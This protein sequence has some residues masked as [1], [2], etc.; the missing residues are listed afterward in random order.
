MQ[1]LGPGA[2]GDETAAP[3]SLQR[4][5]ELA[6]EPLGLQPAKHH[7]ALLNALNGVARGD[8]DRLMV[9]MPPGSAKSTYASLLFP[10]W[11]LSRFPR[12]SIIATSHTQDLA[13]HFGR[14]LR[15]VA[16]D[17]ARLLGYGFE[18]DNNAAYRFR[19]SLGGEYFATGL[20]GGITGRRADLVLI[21][22][23]IKNHSAADSASHR[24]GVWN[25]YRSE[26]S[27]RLK[28]RGRVVLIMTR[29]HVDDLG[30]RLAAAG[31]AWETLRLPAL[32]EANDPLGREPGA[33][34]WPEWE[35]LVQLERRRTM[36]GSR[37]WSALYQQ[38]PRPDTGT[39]FPVARI[40]V[41]DVPPTELATVRAWDLAAT[42]AS[43]GHDP[44]WTVGLKLGRD[45]G[46][47]VF[48]LDVVR[49]RGGPHE[50][51]EA[52][53]HTANLD[54]RSVQIGLPQ[55]PGQA[56]K[57]QVA[58]LTGRLAGYR[59]VASPETGAKLLRASPVAAQVEAGNLVVV[60]GSWTTAFIDEL[61]DFPHGRKDDQVDA[62]S[63][64][65]ALLTDRPP[66]ARRINVPLMAR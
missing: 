13:S 34:L 42:A 43:D 61:R 58:W 32:A 1:T 59:V 20:G 46:G 63:R 54:G 66:T 39:L 14:E 22:D 9:L 17:H 55:D 29:W 19:T 37:V 33:A 2:A 40:V 16:A 36:V 15:R 23:P 62:L 18:R 30:G 38:M 31:D 7:I 56:G 51:A 60:R 5:A 65:F 44:D 27:T 25:W 4:W 8:Y 50:V 3:L 47:R 52:I 53:V 35:N 45:S 24:E 57:Q 11:W 49:L 48:V 21:D 12:D 6:L 26:L 28:P 41:Q 10:A 64:A